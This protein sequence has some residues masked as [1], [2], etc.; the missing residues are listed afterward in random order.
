LIKLNI[1]VLGVNKAIDEYEF[2]IAT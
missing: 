1:V 2:G